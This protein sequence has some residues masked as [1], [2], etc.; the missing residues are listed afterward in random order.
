MLDIATIIALQNRDGGWPYRKNGISWTEPTVFALLAQSVENGDPHSVERGFQWLRTSQRSDGGW[1]PQ[2]SVDQSTWVTSF[3]AL[4]HADAIGRSHHAAAIEWLMSQTGKESSLM[5]RLRSKLA[6]D[7][8]G[9]APRDG[10]PFFPGAAAWVSPTAMSILALE[11]ACR[12]Q[13]SPRVLERIQVGR[14]FLLDRICKD[15]GWNYGRSSVL[16]VEA[17]SYPE[18]TGQAL[19]ALNSV[20]SPQI[21]K[22][23]AAAEGQAKRCQSAEG[24]S[25]LELGLQ[26]HGVVSQGPERKLPCRQLLDAALCILAEAAQRGRNVFLE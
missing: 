20:Q 5:Y 16:G 21:A 12:H 6:G 25:W 26:S 14:Q 22:A 15:G 11:K 8:S 19:L 18:T 2:P 13:A 23:L 17:D 1:A 3:V 4:L 24:L 9:Y 7:N 10:W